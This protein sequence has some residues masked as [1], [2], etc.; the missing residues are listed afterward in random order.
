MKSGT[1][2]KLALY[3]ILAAAMTAP[4]R[5][6]VTFSGLNDELETNARALVALSAASCETAQWR[7]RR[8]YRESDKQL[9][10]ALEALGYYRFDVHKSLSF[11]DECWAAD[12]DVELGEPVSLRQVQVTVS[13]AAE[14]DP[15]I[16][17]ENHNSRPIPGDVLHHGTYEAYKRFIR[18][19]LGTRG[20]FDAQL[21][22]SRVAVDA[23]LQYADIT[24]S[25]ESGPRFHFGEVE[26]SDDILEPQLLARYVEFKPGD[27]YD[28]S[29]ISELHESL[30]GSGFFAS[31]SIR[32]EPVEGME[33]EIPVFVSITAA[34]RHQYTAGVGYA[35]DTGPQGRLGYTNR[36]RNN[37]G[38]QIDARLFVSS[39]E[40]ELTAAYRWPIGKPTAEWAQVY[41]GFQSKETDTSQSDKT[42]L[43]IRMSRNRSRA[44]LETPY[45]DFTYEDFEVGEQTDTSRLIIPG[46]TWER[47]IGR[48]LRRTPEGH[49]I[50][51]DLRGAHDALGSDT[52]FLQGTVSTKWIWSPGLGT[53]FLAR[54][55]I[56]ATAKQ[57]LAQL[58][59]SVR[60][61]A[62]GDT[63]VRGYD[64]ETIGPVDDNGDVTG[65]SHLVALSLEA[66]WKIAGNW[67]IAAFVDSG[68]AFN[69]SD[70][71]FKTGVGLGV[72]WYSPLGPIRIDFAHPL[73][74]A[75]KDFR[76]HITLGPDL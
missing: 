44:W 13:G 42:T 28:A 75:D 37:K 73:D 64:F 43:G 4:A 63:S 10:D 35:T 69:E 71:D 11:D 59:A 15:D 23:E 56:G 68:S 53:R 49:R 36:R 38:H 55:D 14:N 72:R 5:A 76:L 52:T 22:E 24:I 8:L 31:V 25:V 18:S 57:S 58:P 29:K 21:T 19:T 2:P 74:D 12:F 1:S 17:F 7:I 30:S 39:V 40:S 62:G 3:L 9:R 67:A 27:P 47:T 61:F 66:D 54:A 32:A 33:R 46:I 34:K 65:G 51:V 26:F 6:A 45:I 48:D 50:S 41:G 16:D 20:Y 70:P 60:F